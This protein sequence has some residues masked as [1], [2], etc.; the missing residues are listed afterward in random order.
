LTGQSFLKIRLVDE[1]EFAGDCEEPLVEALQ[2][3]QSVLVFKLT[4]IHLQEMTAA[5]MAHWM[6]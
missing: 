6:D 5:A 3:A 2:F 4:A 1:F